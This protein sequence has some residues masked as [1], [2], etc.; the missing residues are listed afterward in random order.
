MG[1]ET[2]EKDEA[3]AQVDGVIEDEKLKVCLCVRNASANWEIWC[4]SHCV[5]LALGRNRSLVH[6]VTP[7]K[8]YVVKS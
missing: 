4:L 6:L 8:S 1:Q 5:R 3:G 2:I 7:R